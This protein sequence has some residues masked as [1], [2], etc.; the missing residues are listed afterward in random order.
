MGVAERPLLCP[1]D[2]SV[3]TRV[4]SPPSVPTR[5]SFPVVPLIVAMCSSSERLASRGE[6]LSHAPDG[7]FRVTET[8]GGCGQ[9]LSQARNSPVQIRLQ[10]P[11]CAGSRQPWIVYGR[12]S[13]A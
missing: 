10:P 1:P 9:G 11:S 8:R 5:T 6:R 2:A 13:N 12:R 3:E 7:D 4:I